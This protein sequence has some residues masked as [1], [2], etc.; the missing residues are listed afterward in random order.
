[1]K[2]VIALCLW[3]ASAAALAQ[4][5]Q[6]K[7]VDSQQ[8][9]G[10]Y[11][12]HYSVFNSTF[13]TP[14]VARLYQ[15]TRAKDRVLVNVSVTKALENGSTLGLPARVSGT[16]INLLQQQRSLEFITLSEGEATYYLASLRHTSEEVINF[17][18]TLQPEGSDQSM[19]VRFSR[20]LYLEP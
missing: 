16:A 14:E 8:T 11:T 15:L 19:V 5:Q 1:M 10:E 13:I 20:T 2:K 7:P 18:I 3:L 12:V 17:A 6:V 9:F 4:I